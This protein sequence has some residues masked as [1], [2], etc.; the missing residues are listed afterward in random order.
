M[1][2][3]HDWRDLYSYSREKGLIIGEVTAEEFA[4][5]IRSLASGGFVEIEGFTLPVAKE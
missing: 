2:W 5:L 4:G 1:R 3:L